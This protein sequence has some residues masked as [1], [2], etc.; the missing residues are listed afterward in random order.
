[1]GRDECSHSILC[2]MTDTDTSG[3]TGMIIRIG[4][5]INGIKHVIVCNE[6]SANAAKL[7][8]RVQVVAVLVKNLYAVISSISH[9]KTPLG[10]HF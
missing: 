7:L 5:R 6:Q 8:I 1:M 4:F 3:P 10:I 2:S 9:E